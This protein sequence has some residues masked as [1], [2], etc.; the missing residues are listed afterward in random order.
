LA[1]P[2]GAQ[3]IL[4]LPFENHSRSSA[5]DWIG[6]SAAEGLAAH[7]RLPAHPVAANARYVIRREERAAAFDLLGLPP[8]VGL[9]YATA[10]KI[11]EITGA[12]LLVFG[13]FDADAGQLTLSA[14]VLEM[15][16]PH[17]EAPCQESGRL[18]DLLA[19]QD[20]LARD[21]AASGGLS[22]TSG[23][24]AGGAGAGGAGAGTV[25]LEAWESYIRGVIAG[26]SPQ[27]FKYFR[28]AT[29]QDPNFLPAAFQL[30]RISFQNRDYSDAVQW[31]EKLGIENPN[32]LEASFLI[33]MSDYHLRQWEKAEAAFLAVTATLP[34]NEAFNNLGIVQMREHKRA[35]ALEN[36]EKA[37]EGDPNDVDYAY[38]LACYYLRAADYP[39]AARHAR[40]V[41]AKKPNDAEAKALLASAL[42]DTP[43]EP[44]ERLKYNFEEPNFRQLRMI[45]QRM[46]EEKDG[47]SAGD[48]S[49]GAPSPAAQH[50]S[51]GRELAELHQDDA[52][53]R[54]FNEAIKLDPASVQAYLDLA[55][56][57][58]RAG[59]SGAAEEC[60]RRAAELDRDKKDPEPY[61]LLAR[62]YQHQGKA[63]PA[64]AAL[65]E[66]LERDPNNIAARELERQIKVKPQ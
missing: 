55:R 5:L 21:L 48:A 8:T 11:G 60:A 14:R 9:S 31:L 53:A 28:E 12:D 15:R 35:A 6:E 58:A 50:L 45:L 2:A 36:L 26:P 34:L 18:A 33:G 10:I 59:R 27:Q 64:R 1:I 19:I 52:A 3:A 57:Y 17:L 65:K 39:Q 47:S 66:A 42:Q 29:R 4:I 49:Q 41:L 54:E 61:L 32:F 13:S 23:V 38:N 20:R 62:I 46:A 22:G 51:R 30:G 44:P 25:S 16:N 37:F 56:L 40:E 7:W 24:G 63:D 43:S